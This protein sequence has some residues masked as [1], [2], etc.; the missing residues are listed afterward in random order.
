M[1]GQ[2][3]LANAATPPFLQ[4]D[5]P[6]RGV[7]PTSLHQAPSQPD[8]I[9]SEILTNLRRM[10]M[11]R[12]E[13]GDFVNRT[14][15]AQKSAPGMAL[16]RFVQALCVGKGRIMNTLDYAATHFRDTPHVLTALEMVFKSQVDPGTGTGTTWAAPLVL[17]QP[18]ANQFT[19][20]IKPLT[21]LDRAGFRPVPFNLSFARATG[22]IGSAWVGENQPIPVSKMSFDK[23]TLGYAKQG[24]IA[25]VSN[26]L[27]TQS[28]PQAASVIANDLVRASA[29]FSDEQLIDPDV[30]AVPGV[31]PGSIS[32]GGTIV[33]S[34]GNTPTAVI[35]DLRTLFEYF[36]DNV[37][38]LSQ[39]LLIMSERVAFHWASLVGTSGEFVFEDL[40]VSGG[41][42]WGVPV[43]TSA[44]TL[45]TGNSPSEENVLLCHPDSVILADGGV[46]IDVATR[47]SVVLDTAPSSPAELY[48]LWQNDS[49]GVRLIRYLNYERR[50][51]NAVIC[52]TGI[53][54]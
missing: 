39:S 31:S 28:S 48:S 20:L 3:S 26:E 21:I 17:P 43:L 51:S 13:L 7:D 1:D 44:Y 45:P 9:P 53:N 16:G 12:D 50:R 30:A 32:N 27:A 40:T 22:G 37:I 42:I 29:K 49:T 35:A 8:L 11:Q 6:L 10:I 19:E 14:K 38:P 18:L 5:W 34:T 52:L 23:V 4:P 2:A 15:Y 36:V 24:T 46:A 47:G 54:L 33:T 25:V 41:S